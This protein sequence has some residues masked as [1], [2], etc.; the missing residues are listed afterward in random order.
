MICR[1]QSTTTMK[2]CLM[3]QAHQGEVLAHVDD[4]GDDVEEVEAGVVLQTMVG[5]ALE[6]GGVVDEVEEVEEEE[7][8]ED[9]DSF[10]RKVHKKD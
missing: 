6:K 5:A 7:Q 3:S 1:V 9:V 8:S 10:K 4:V 2:H